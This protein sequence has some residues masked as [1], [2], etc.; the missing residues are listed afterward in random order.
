MIG[1]LTFIMVALRWSES[2]MP[3][4]F[5]SEISVSRY[6]FSFATFMK[7]ESMTSPASRAVSGF[8]TCADPSEPTSSIR[9]LVADPMTTDC[10]LP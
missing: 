10:S 8:M 1:S 6:S 5:A 3:V 9:T 2:M 7:E 4:S